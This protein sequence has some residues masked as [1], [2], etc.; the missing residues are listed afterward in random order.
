MD[1]FT[2][3][4]LMDPEIMAHVA[5]G[6][7]PSHPAR[8]AGFRRRLVRNEVY[9]AI[10]PDVSEDVEGVV[11]LS[12]SAEALERLDS[13]EGEYYERKTVMAESNGKKMNVETYVLTA[14]Y[15]HLLSLIPWSLEEFQSAGKGI[16]ARDYSGFSRVSKRTADD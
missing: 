15:R 2:Y 7:F 8:L 6:I 12:L 4:T 11:Y 9:P 13:F 14:E 10:I 16:F 3:G 1:L 5:G